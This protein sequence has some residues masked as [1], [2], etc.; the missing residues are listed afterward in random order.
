[1]RLRREGWLLPL[2][3][4]NLVLVYIPIM[5]CQ[6]VIACQGTSNG[7]SILQVATLFCNAPVLLSFLGA[8]CKHR[9][10]RHN[11]G[12]LLCLSTSALAVLSAVLSLI[13]FNGN[14]LVYVVWSLLLTL[15]SIS[16]FFS[17]LAS[18]AV[19]SQN[20]F[21]APPN[22]MIIDISQ[23]A[24]ATLGMLICYYFSNSLGGRGLLLV[25]ASLLLFPPLILWFL[26]VNDSPMPALFVK[27]VEKSYSL[28]DRESI[29]NYFNDE[30]LKND[31]V[32]DNPYLLMENESFGKNLIDTDAQVIILMNI[33]YI[34][35][36]AISQ[37]VHC[38]FLVTISE[39]S[40][41]FTLDRCCFLYTVGVVIST[42]VCCIS[43]P[44]I[45]HYNICNKVMSI[46]YLALS[47]IISLFLMSD[48]DTYVGKYILSYCAI[49][50]NC[51]LLEEVIDSVVTS[52]YESI[53]LP[54]MKSFS[55]RDYVNSK[56]GFLHGVG[57]LAG[58]IIFG[59]IAADMEV[60]SMLFTVAAI[61]TTLT[62]V[63][64]P[65]SLLFVAADLR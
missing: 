3:Y 64:T 21:S 12:R 59:V 41:A 34:V 1:M 10:E 24:S 51:Q 65:L 6:I 58:P 9:A 17:Q 62:V 25:A 35:T 32:K 8:Y 46:L 61:F 31:L 26:C 43:R 7:L 44:F 57:S 36:V 11:T 45:I 42:A 47:T 50:I 63:T 38:F 54:A 15:L 48:L 19:I 18:F 2:V 13:P 30:R 23:A 5:F 37:G 55:V 53:H 28:C 39:R 4:A 49:I 56:V 22:I 60:E 14:V 52:Y 40:A 29:K 20:H 16:C 33:I 27:D